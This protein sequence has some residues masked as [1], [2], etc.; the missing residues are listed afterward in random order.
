[1]QKNQY[2][3]SFNEIY[4]KNEEENDAGVLQ[5]DNIEQKA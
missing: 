4:E 1:M 5:N 3:S 2:V